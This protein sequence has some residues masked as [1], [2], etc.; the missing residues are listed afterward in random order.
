M[1]KFDP[2]E[3]GYSNPRTRPPELLLTDRQVEQQLLKQLG[4][5]LKTSGNLAIVNQRLETDNPLQ[6]IRTTGPNLAIY[7]RRTGKYEIKQNFD[8]NTLR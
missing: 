1:L 8:G 5:D 6:A 4:L 3:L 2:D 7:N